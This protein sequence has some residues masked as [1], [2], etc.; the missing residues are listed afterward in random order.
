MAQISGERL[1][2]H[3]SS[4]FHSVSSTEPH[5]RLAISIS[6]T[7]G[8]LIKNARTYVQD[9]IVVS[10][11]ILDEEQRTLKEVSH[12]DEVKDDPASGIQA[13]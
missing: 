5:S 2:D 7:D 13:P 9:I 12:E 3:W 8:D 4:G 10:L 6:F 11:G 1:Q